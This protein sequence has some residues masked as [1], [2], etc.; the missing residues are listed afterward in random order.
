MRDR[1]PGAVLLDEVRVREDE[2]PVQNRHD[3]VDLLLRQ[4]GQAAQLGARQGALGGDRVLDRLLVEARLDGFGRGDEQ[5]QQ[6]RGDAGGDA[7]HVLADTD[8]SC[9]R[10]LVL[11]A[12]EERELVRPAHEIAFVVADRPVVRGRAV[13]LLPERRQ[14]DVRL[15]KQERQADLVDPGSGG[16]HRAHH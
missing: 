3:P 2:P 1:A 4:A 5:R 13:H 8:E 7:C 16:L 14:D 10:Q 9:P 15:R 11:R 12:P 6:A